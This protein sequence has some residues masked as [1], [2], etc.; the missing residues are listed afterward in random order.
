LPP[1]GLTV[2]LSKAK[3]FAVFGTHK[4]VRLSQEDFTTE[5]QRSQRNTERRNFL[6]AG[7]ARRVFSV[8]LCDLC[9]SVVNLFAAVR[10]QDD[11]K[12]NT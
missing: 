1:P 7:G 6:R 11:A 2:V 8:F 10:Q 9:V 5:A 3:D 12:E 4:P